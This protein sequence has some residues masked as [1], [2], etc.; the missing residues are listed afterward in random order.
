MLE[1]CK[2]LLSKFGVK[3]EQ[4]QIGRTKIFFRAGV[5][6]QLEDSATRINKCAAVPFA[7]PRCPK[8]F[9]PSE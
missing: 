3:P 7:H 6:G 2:Q 4:Y 5:L 8:N 1:T 9:H